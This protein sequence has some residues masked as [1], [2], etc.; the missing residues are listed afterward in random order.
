MFSK[1]FPSWT[2][3]LLTVKMLSGLK[4]VV[5]PET[6]QSN[7]RIK[8]RSFF[9]KSDL[10]K[11]WNSAAVFAPTLS[12]WMSSRRPLFLCLSQSTHGFHQ[13][14]FSSVA[15]RFLDCDCRCGREMFCI[16]Q[17][18]GHTGSHFQKAKTFW[19]EHV[20]LHVCIFFFRVLPF[21]LTISNAVVQIHIK[22]IME[23]YSV[24]I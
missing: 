7:A 19:S 13:L 12:L 14:Y 4:M 8:G 17:F 1:C 16:S 22:C 11:L 3:K 15:Q 9:Y 10:C 2:N 23:T 20:F 18:N 21:L 5:G 24:S 6:K